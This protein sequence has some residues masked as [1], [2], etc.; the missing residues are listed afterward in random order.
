MKALIFNGKL[1]F[2]TNMPIPEPPKD[3]ALIKIL[4]VGIC[5]TDIEITKGYMNFQGIPG[6]E[7]VGIVENVN[8]ADKSWIGKR[9]VGD[10][11]CACGND[12][13]E[14]CIKNLGRH[15]PNRT[16]LGI[17]ERNGCFA[18]Y[19]TLPIN[20]LLEVP[21]KITDEIA[22]LTEP[23]A[24]G[25][26]ILEQINITKK[27]EVLIVGDG[28]LG[29]LINHAL[30]TTSAKI[31]HVGKHKEKLD[32]ALKNGSKTVLLNQMPDKLF[33]VVVEV[34]GSMSGFEF[35]LKHTKPRGTLILKSTIAANQK[36]DLT[37]V[38]V[39][40]ISVIGSRCGLFKPALNYIEQNPNPLSEFI[41]AVYPAEN[42]LSAFEH[43]KR[44]GSMKVL[45]D[46][47]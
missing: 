12:N 26:E 36:I 1:T 17:S 33:D 27:H 46:F 21:Q 14:Y 35:S 45:I 44:R 47:R 18:E 11:N 19:I 42:A 23:L 40:E 39:N 5:N 10:I 43:A 4:M 30:S 38:V 6:H 3:E 16:T 32:I 24:A 41:E 31:T 13:C 2:V 8:N 29:L 15:C 22:T 7:F 9:V 25:F 20:N 34:T 28:K 37:P